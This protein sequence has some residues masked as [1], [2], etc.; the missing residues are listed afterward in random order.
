MN[1][2]PYRILVICFLLFG[3]IQTG[4]SQESSLKTAD[5]LYNAGQWKTAAY[6]YETFVSTHKEK[7][8]A[9]VYNRLGYAKHNTGS[10]QE[11]LNAYI[12]AAA[13][14]PPSPIL[15]FLYSR[16][17]R[18]YA[19]LNDKTNAMMYLEKAI[20]SGYSNVG[21]LKENT[22]FDNLRMD[23]HFQQLY[24]QLEHKILPCTA[25][26]KYAEFDFW[27][28]S[29]MVVQSGTNYVVGRNTIEKSA[30]DCVLLETWV[31][32]TGGETGK[33]INYIDTESGKWVQ[34]YIGSRGEVTTYTDGELRNGAMV[35]SY[36][37]KL[38]SGVSVKGKF[39]FQKLENGDVRQFQEQTNDD[40]KSWQLLFDFTYKK[41]E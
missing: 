41:A 6:W 4:H 17:A 13:K 22:D 1:A 34:V 29:W 10:Y 32:A 15:P 18:S 25:N 20:G 40:G 8:S 14:N 23:S 5:S 39:T 36:Q 33:S 30:G 11:A 9:V 21:E 26:D 2:Y 31:S 24:T 16:M 35:F 28:G 3:F 7:A 27:V 37:K 38:K 19:V 12:Q